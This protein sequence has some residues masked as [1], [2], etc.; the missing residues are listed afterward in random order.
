MQLISRITLT[1]AV[2]L[3][4]QH[5]PLFH[6]CRSPTQSRSLCRPL[7][8][9]KHRQRVKDPILHT[10]PSDLIRPRP[11]ASSQLS[12]KSVA[13]PRSNHRLFKCQTRS[14]KQFGP[15]SSSQTQSQLICLFV[16]F[17]H[18]LFPT[19]LSTFAPTTSRPYPTTFA[20]GLNT[21][22]IWS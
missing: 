14:G 1:T 13:D 10:D 17:H 16:L 9:S 19:T 11:T 8:A 12:F 3:N 20:F 2:Q 4:I 7:E 18:H 6:L 22:N 21:A 15:H 5:L